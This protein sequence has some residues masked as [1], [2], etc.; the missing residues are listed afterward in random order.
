MQPST[1]IPSMSNEEMSI[2]DLLAMIISSKGLHEGLFGLGVK[3]AIATGAVGPTPE[4]MYPGAM[5]G[6][7]GFVLAKSEFPGPHIVDAAQVNPRP[8]VKQKRISK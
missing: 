7:C 6:V 5:L 3:F 8:K 4:A 1:E 2:E